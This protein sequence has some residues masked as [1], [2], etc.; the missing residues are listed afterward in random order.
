MSEYPLIYPNN[1]HKIKLAIY[2]SKS[3]FSSLS[4]SKFYVLVSDTPFAFFQSSRG[5]RLRD[6]FFLFICVTNGGPQ[7]PSQE[8]QGQQLDLEV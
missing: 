1:I 5:L 3:I 2:L 8:G 4:T 7:L 6:P